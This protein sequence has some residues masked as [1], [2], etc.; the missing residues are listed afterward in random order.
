MEKVS[1]MILKGRVVN[2]GNVSG[3]AVV[4][5]IPFSFIGDF[6]LSSGCLSRGHPMEGQSLAGK[7][8]VCPTGKGGTVAPYIAYEAM[9]ANIAPVAILCQKADPILALCAITIDIPMMDRIEGDII[10]QIVT[11]DRVQ[12]LGD[13]GMVILD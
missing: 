1:R 7:I 10:H 6:D 3:E 12:V 13:T 8:L 2:G 11:G 5:N 9:K 4:L